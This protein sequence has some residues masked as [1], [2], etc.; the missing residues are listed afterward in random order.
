M[1]S[2]STADLFDRLWGLYDEWYYRHRVIAENEVK[3]VKS[4]VHKYPVLEVGVGTGFFA[5]RVGVEYGLDPSIN[6]L[7]KAAE[8]GVEVVQGIGE[9]LPFRGMVFGS[10]LLVVT[11]CFVDSPSLVLAESARVVRRGGDVVACIVPRDSSWGRKYVEEA[12][13]GHVFYSRARFYTVREV[14]EMM[15]E[16]GLEAVEAKGVL[17]FKPWERPYPEKPSSNIVDKGFVCI[18]GVKK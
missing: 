12:K 4:M 7:F 10:V 18:R 15:K 13:R 2:V 5:Q 8:R 11:L 1:I 17:G 6:M 14:Y 16:A 9:Q 3:L